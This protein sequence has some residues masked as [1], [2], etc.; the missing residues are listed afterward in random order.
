MADGTPQG[1]A[2]QDASGTQI[3]DGTPE[4]SKKFSRA[5]KPVGRA[6]DVKE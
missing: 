6:P 4:M 2:G 5:R 3:G 1:S